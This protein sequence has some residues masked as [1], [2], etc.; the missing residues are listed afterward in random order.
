MPNRFG[1]AAWL[2]QV[3]QLLCVPSS[4]HTPLQQPA[5]V[6]P[7]HIV[8]PQ[9]QT[10]FE[11]VRPFAHGGVHVVDVPWQTPLLHD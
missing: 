1:Q 10:P 7:V 11:Q 9:R 6:R 3:P 8:E 2:V 4:V 5:T